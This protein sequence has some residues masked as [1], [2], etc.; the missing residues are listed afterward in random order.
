MEIACPV[1]VNRLPVECPK[2]GPYD[3]STVEQSINVSRQ[4]YW[5]FGC[6]L[7]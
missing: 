3:G 6:I 7:C 1:D 2:R 4:K 5:A